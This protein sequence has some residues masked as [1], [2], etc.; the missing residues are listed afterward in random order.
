MVFV[1]Y[2]VTRPGV[3]NLR[4]HLGGMQV[5]FGASQ[6]HS[7]HFKKQLRGLIRIWEPEYYHVNSGAWF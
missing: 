7:V 5:N 2:E 3:K 1:W 4:L 6:G